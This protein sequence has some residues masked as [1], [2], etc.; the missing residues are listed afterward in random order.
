MLCNIVN[1]GM[2][3]HMTSN[4]LRC[5]HF[6]K[7]I[8]HECKKKRVRANKGTRIYC[9][10]RTNCILWKTY[11]ITSFF[12]QRSEWSIRFCSFVNTKAYRT[13]TYK[14][15]TSDWIRRSEIQL[16]NRLKI[17]RMH[18]QKGYC[19]PEQFSFHIFINH[20][21]CNGFFPWA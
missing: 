17:K 19:Q 21:K 5:L 20:T 3:S 7:D 2:T 10:L 14:Q 9:Q 13:T 8:C 4:K 6:T 15:Q 11:F 1:D 18:H 12:L 16:K